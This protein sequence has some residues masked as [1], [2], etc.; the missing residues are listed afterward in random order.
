[1]G[2]ETENFHPVGNRLDINLYFSHADT[3]V[4][5]GDAQAK[6]REPMKKMLK[7]MSEEELLVKENLSLVS[8]GLFNCQNAEQVDLA[9]SF[10]KYL[11]SIGLTRTNFPLFLRL[12]A[13]NNPWVIDAL[14]GRRVSHLLFASI[15]PSDYSIKMAFEVLSFFHPDILYSKALES[16]LGIIETAYYDPDDGFEIYPLR[17]A[18]LNTIGKYL[19]KKKDQYEVNNS[20]ILKILDRLSGIGDYNKSQPKTILSR[21]AF[22][23]RFAYFDTQKELED[24]IPQVLLFHQT[25]NERSVEPSPP[26]ESRPRS[27]KSKEES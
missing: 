17:L 2:Y 25:R 5:L 14:V 16:V 23:I 7:L 10:S 11:S 3:I 22:G 4:G 15:P 18:D 24:V 19:D 12:I 9:V 27:R 6:E 1:M 8:S 21:H 26:E 13:T 20:L